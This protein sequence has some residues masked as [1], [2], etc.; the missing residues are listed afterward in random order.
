M[1]T[2]SEG[3]H[4]DQRGV[5]IWKVPTALLIFEY[6]RGR[7]FWEGGGYMYVAFN[8]HFVAQS[9]LTGRRASLLMLSTPL[10]VP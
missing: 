8:K 10:T 6:I 4:P 9:T 2:A 3:W 7:P 5:D 1:H